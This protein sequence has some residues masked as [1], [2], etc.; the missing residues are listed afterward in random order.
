VVVNATAA[1]RA[2]YKDTKFWGSKGTNYYRILEARQE[3]NTLTLTKTDKP[4]YGE[5]NSP[6]GES[7]TVAVIRTSYGIFPS[8]W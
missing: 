4:W 6:E 3:G 7:L 1:S 8:P 2:R 5:T